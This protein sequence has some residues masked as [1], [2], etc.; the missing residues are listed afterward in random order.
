MFNITPSKYNIY[1]VGNSLNSGI[2]GGIV[3]LLV[4]ISAAFINYLLI[5][6]VLA[7]VALLVIVYG[8]RFILGI[9]IVS[10][11]TLV[12]DLGSTI[13][14][15]VQL[16][17][18]SLLGYLFLKRYGIDFKNYPRFPREVNYFFLIYYSAL[19]IST[20]FSEHFFEGTEKIIQQSVFFLVAYIFFSLLKDIRY[21]KTYINSLIAVSLILASSS[22][23]Q[24]ALGGF[25]IVDFT[26]G[27]RYRVSSL[28]SNIDTTTLFFIIVFPIILTFLFTKVNKTKRPLLFLVSLILTIGLFLTNSRSAIM[29][30]LVSLSF[31]LFYL[32]KG[33]FKY[34]FIA[35]ITITVLF[36]SIEP[37]NEFAGLIFRVQ[38]GMS[39]R[40]H[41]WNLV[42]N[43]IKDN[44]ILGIGP[45]SYRYEMINYLP[46]MLNTWV[47]NLM[48]DLN[49]ATL[50]SNNAH[51]LFLM[52]A[53]DMG[54]MGII[55][56][57]YLII[58]FFRIAKQTIKKAGEGN[59]ELFLLILSVSAVT[60]SVFIR[61]IFDSIGILTYGYLTN[62][63]PF[64]LLFGILIYFYQKPKEYFVSDEIKS[65]NI[66]F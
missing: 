29:A 59:R 18:F 1:R 47:A 5:G 13:R 48:I 16:T 39:E 40:N 38:E 12:S 53:S 60:G 43:I 65:A 57:F 56:L 4:L 23:Y 19:S 22:I 55:T 63:L 51:S 17:N 37:L 33:L 54:F 34:L 32:N 26:L 3:L 8:E 15:I 24:F 50:G 10:F 27:V 30:I 66:L 61:C 52:F 35:A 31:I 20:I 49:I 46:V 64:W 36:L 41:F 21:V 2:L 7:I 62:D 42:V 9:V 6:V 44:P 58:L 45:G 25:Q 14:L 28:I 11:F